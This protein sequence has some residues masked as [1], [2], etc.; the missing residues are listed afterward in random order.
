MKILRFLPE[1]VKHFNLTEYYYS[2]GYKNI[3]FVAMSTDIDSVPFEEG[4]EQYTFVE[5]DL[6]SRY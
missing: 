5:N 4:S 6:A 3:H 1:Y 2:F